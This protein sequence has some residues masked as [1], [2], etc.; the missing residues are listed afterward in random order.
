MLSGPVLDGE[1]FSPCD[2]VE[3]PLMFWK[4]LVRTG[5][6]GTPQASAYLA[7]QEQ[8]LDEPR[9]YVK[10]PK[11]DEA[12]KIDTFRFAIPKLAELT[13]LDFSAL[14]PYDTF[15]KKGPEGAEAAAKPMTDWSDAL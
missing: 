7:N 6:D 1:N 8:L 12:P 5:K 15:R 2:D 3:V 9:K 11:N 13:G 14:T 10:R 4:I